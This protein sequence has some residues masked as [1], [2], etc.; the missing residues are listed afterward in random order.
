MGINRHTREVHDSLCLR[1]FPKENLILMNYRISTWWL[2]LLKK[3]LLYVTHLGAV[4]Q[5]L[6]TTN[7]IMT[8]GYTYAKR[9]IKN[10]RDI[11]CVVAH[12]R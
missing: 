7:N 2:H 1:A 11:F 6:V 8:L 3:I 10:P 4:E 12:I 9:R 5:I